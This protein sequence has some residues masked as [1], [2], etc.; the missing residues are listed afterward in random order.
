MKENKNEVIF[1]FMSVM[2]LPLNYELNTRKQL[3]EAECPAMLLIIFNFVFLP[4][5]QHLMHELDSKFDGKRG[6]KAYPRTLLLI[7]VLYCFSENINLYKGMVKECK[8]NK[9]LIIILDGKTPSRGTFTNFLN[10]SDNEIIHRVFVSTLVLLND[11][12]A[13]SIARVFIDGTDAIVRG[14]RNYYIKQRDLKAMELLNEWNLLHDGSS[15]KINKTLKELNIKLKE[16]H[17]DKEV[18]ELINLAI[19]RIKIYKH[20]VY[21]KK[22]RYEKEFEKRG[23]VKLSIVFPESVYLK[24]KKGIFDFCFNLQAIMTDNHVIFTSIL[25]PQPNDQKVFEDVYN[26]IKKTLCI[27]LEMQCMYGQRTNFS[28]FITSFL[29]I[30]IV[31]D[32]G[33][34]TIKNLYF[35][36]IHRINALIMPNTEAR[37]ENKKLKEKTG[38]T[39]KEK[40]SIKKHFKRVKGGYECRNGRFLKLLRIIPIKHRKPQDDSIPD[41]CKTKRQVLWKKAL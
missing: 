37:K 12:N 7:V 8:K 25:L 22:D 35:I 6:R 13:L 39:K 3:I 32:A 24:T 17:D 38:N 4:M 5:V 16:F 41:I 31:A 20:S 21:N 23:D 34:F 10:K 18:V 15:E 30:I 40:S 33:Y 14:S 19:R 27:F 26:Q 28:Y 11:I 29:N 1:F 36:F 9:F 2:E